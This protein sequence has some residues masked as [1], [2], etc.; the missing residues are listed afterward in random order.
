MKSLR[1]AV[2]PVAGR[3]T[4][5][6]PATKAIPKEM[7][8]LVDRP[9]VQYA[10][11]EA[12]GAGIKDVILVTG[13]GKHAIEDHF[14][15]NPELER[16]LEEQGKDELLDLVRMCSDLVQTAYIRQ[17]VPLGLGHAV[18]T[19]KDLIGDEPFAVFL[20][21]DVIRSEIPCMKQLRNV[22][23]ARG[24]SVLAVMEVPREETG[25]YG[26]LDIEDLGNGL[27]RVLDMVE[28]PD[29]ADAPSN[30]V[31]IGR[32]LLMPEVFEELENTKPG[33]KGEIQLTDAL[34]S[35]LGRQE[36]YALQF[37][38]TRYD[39]GTKRGYAQAVVQFTLQHPELGDSFREFLNGLDLS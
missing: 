11:E 33:A 12:V 14:D 21:D 35:L 27:Y 28:K 9:V 7:V 37:E 23:E 34:K 17:K 31:V 3:G 18:L 25:R 1:K 26:V 10:I 38:G 5:F 20:P 22:H 13:R 29:P 2:F 6:L 15:P 8:P 30:L 39:T 19:A 24:A 16:F 32:Y 36:I 4:R